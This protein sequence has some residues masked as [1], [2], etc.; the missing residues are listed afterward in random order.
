MRIEVEDLVLRYGDVTALDR[1]TLTLEEGKIYGLL[2]RNGSGKTSLLS[3]LAAFRRQTAGDVRIGGQ[4]VF[5]NGRLTSRISLIR[6]AGE[7]VDIGTAEDALYFAEWL[8][9]GWDADYARSLMDLFGLE[10]KKN[11]K[12]MSK[13]QR[14]AMGVVVGLAGRAPLTM[15]DES[16]LGMDAPSRYAFYDALLADYMAHPRTIILSTHLI[17]EVSSLFE[18]VVIIDRGRLVVHEESQTLLSRGAAVTGPAAQVDAFTG[19][20]TV[21]GAKELGPTKS[22]MVYGDLDDARRRKAAESGLELGPIAMQDLFVH[23]TGESR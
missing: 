12:E 8:R 22:A 6:D 14:S 4:P 19:G 17:E 7:T 21:L 3:I 18:E 23:L 11:V 10:P 2:G 9:P 5:E 20:L 1:L 16:Y 15:F 13:G